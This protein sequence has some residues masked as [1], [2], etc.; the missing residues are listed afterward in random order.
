MG[1]Q[2][3]TEAHGI[4]CLNIMTSERQVTLCSLKPVM[5]HINSE[6]LQDQEVDSTLTKQMRRIM[7]EDLLLQL[8]YTQEM[9]NMLNIS[10]FVDPRFK[11]SMQ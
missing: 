10:S 7:R 4:S 5:E 8:R 9:K 2:Q 1:C 11:G 6:I 3:G